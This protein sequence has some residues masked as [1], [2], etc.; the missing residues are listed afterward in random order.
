[1]ADKL[2]ESSIHAH[3]QDHFVEPIRTY[4]IIFALLLVFMVMTIAVWFVDLG[5]FGTVIAMAIAITKAVLVV[6]FFMHVR[7]ASRLTWIFSGAAFVWLMILFAFTFNDYWTRNDG[8][9]PHKTELTTLPRMAAGE[10]AFEQTRTAHP[11]V[12]P[13]DSMQQEGTE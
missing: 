9:T 3:D 5:G 8:I 13:H 12:A 6:L 7:H 11:A 1:M 10:P 2:T 4:A